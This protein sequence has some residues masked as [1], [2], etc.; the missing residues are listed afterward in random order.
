VHVDENS[1]F[2]TEFYDVFTKLIQP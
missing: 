2:H 1:Q